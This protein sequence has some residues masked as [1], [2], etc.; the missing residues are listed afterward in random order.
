MSRH[1]NAAMRKSPLVFLLALLALL[2]LACTE[3]N[4]AP[5]DADGDTGPLDGDVEDEDGDETAPD[6]DA[7]DP[8]G[9]DSGDIVLDDL[10]LNGP[11]AFGW[12]NAALVTGE[13]EQAVTLDLT[14][15]IPSGTG[16]FPLVVF[17]HGFM[18]SPDMFL[19]YGERLASW[20]VAV[21]MPQ[22]PGSL[23]SPKTHQEQAG[24]LAAILD[25]ALSAGAQESLGE[26][27]PERIGLAGHSMGGKLS[28]LLA[29]QDTRPK[30]VFGVDPVD[31][32]PPTDFDQED[33]PSVTQGRMSD[34][35]VPF[36]ALGETL[37]G[38]GGLACAP[39]AG[40][41]QQF[42]AHAQS[43]ALEIDMLGANHM[44]FVDDPDCGLPCM[45]CPKGTDDPAVTR[46]L[47]LK[48]MTAFFLATL[49]G[50]GELYD[51]LTGTRM[52]A[53]VS[54]GLVSVNTKNGFGTVD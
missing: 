26:I 53:D 5:G 51:Y 38:E 25:W 45:I 27:H 16:P 40:N 46:A 15:A 32:G 2:A 17:T 30:A 50:R 6:G 22:M 3:E 23:S 7:P 31:S 4:S 52:Q 18:L 29:S 37:N 39:A 10:S 35:R 11:I 42:F 47:T 9:D 33:Y 36:V 13:G 8:D 19:S 12:G 20:G 24:Y 54:A 34:I 41:F 44:S 14:L 49:S 1:K 28:F 48:Y 21:V 43:P